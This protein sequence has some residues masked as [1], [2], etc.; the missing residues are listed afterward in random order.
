MKNLAFTVLLVLASN[1]VLAGEVGA[2]SPNP[3]A[4]KVELA[5]VFLDPGVSR[6]ASEPFSTKATVHQINELN[7]CIDKFNAT[8]DADTEAKMA[9]VVKQ[10]QF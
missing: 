3:E 1:G 6:W 7:A 10:M 4:I 2:F 9:E 8:L 5:S